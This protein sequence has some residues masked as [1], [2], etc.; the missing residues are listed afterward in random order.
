MS[1]T[2]SSTARDRV[3]ADYRERLD[4]GED[5]DGGWPSLDLPTTDR[6]LLN[7]LMAGRDID[8]AA[9]IVAMIFEHANAQF[10][11]SGAAAWINQP[12]RPDPTEAEKLAFGPPLAAC[13]RLAERGLGWIDGELTLEP[14]AGARL[15]EAMRDAAQ[16]FYRIGWLTIA[17]GASTLGVS[18][19][20]DDAAQSLLM[21]QDKIN[22]RLAASGA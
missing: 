15:G 20:F 7:G 3:L 4:K 16:L 8:T 19:F 13:L 5:V 10:T 2:P 11:A 17:G 1:E 12:G 14:A 9:K 6:R 18:Q 22:A 21:E